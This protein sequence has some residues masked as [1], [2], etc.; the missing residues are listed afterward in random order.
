MHVDGHYGREGLP[1]E[2]GEVPTHEDDDAQQLLDALLV[3]LVKLALLDGCGDLLG[4]VDVVH[5]DDALRGPLQDP[6]GAVA[7]GIGQEAPARG[8]R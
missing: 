5:G 4:P 6:G 7:A 1:R 2:L 8:L 3:V